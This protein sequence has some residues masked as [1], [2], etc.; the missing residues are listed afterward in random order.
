MKPII[1]YANIYV[2]M[3]AYMYEYIYVWI[4]W[5]PWN[6]EHPVVVGETELGSQLFPL[7][8][9]RDL[10]TLPSKPVRADSGILHR[11]GDLSQL[12]IRCQ[13]HR[14]GR[15][16]SGSED[17]PPARGYEAVNSRETLFQASFP[18]QIA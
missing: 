1:L 14:D 17:I 9:S 10:R 16:V 3:Y 7:R 12:Q 5:K 11:S 6:V 2:C 13:G 18:F 4:Y 8:T 15:L